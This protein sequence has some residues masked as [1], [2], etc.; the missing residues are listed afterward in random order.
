MKATQ[1]AHVWCTNEEVCMNE[2]R[3]YLAD[4]GAA[5]RECKPD[6]KAKKKRNN[7]VKTEAV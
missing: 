6:P 2:K 7:V 3:H 5:G 1:A 4:P